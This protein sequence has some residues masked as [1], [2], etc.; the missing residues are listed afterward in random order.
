MSYNTLSLS[1]YIIYAS[2]HSSLIRYLE[3]L[4]KTYANITVIFK[5]LIKLFRYF[6]R[7]NQISFDYVHVHVDYIVTD[8][9]Y[10]SAIY[11]C[12]VYSVYY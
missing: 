7:A 6:M 10:T 11:Y 4:R 1:I 8:T 5:S 2:Y 9:L 12:I 3:T